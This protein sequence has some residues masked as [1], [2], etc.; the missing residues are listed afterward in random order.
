MLENKI[1]E[2]EQKG[3]DNVVDDN[4]DDSDRDNIIRTII[5][6][7]SCIIDK[8]N[9]VNDS[10][11]SSSSSLLLLSKTITTDIKL[12]ILYIYDIKDDQLLT[13]FSYLKTIE[14]VSVD[15]IC[16]YI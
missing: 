16:R 12:Q 1:K 5:T 15:Q 13:I 2:M 4:I 7:Q 14:V 11:Q 8:N 9:S 3:G 10:E 6:T